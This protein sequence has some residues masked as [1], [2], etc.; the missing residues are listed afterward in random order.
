MHG[1]AGLGSMLGMRQ[2]FVWRLT[3]NAAKNKYE[4]EPCYPDGS[5]PMSAKDATN[6]KTFEEANGDLA[7]LRARGDGFAYT[8]GFWLT[9]ATGFLFLD[10]DECI[11]DGKLNKIADLFFLSLPGACYEWSSSRRGMHLF[12]RGDVGK[13]AKR[14]PKGMGIELY[15]H[16]RGIAFGLDGQV[17]GNADMDHSSAMQWIVS[18]YFPPGQDA[19]EVPDAEFFD[20]DP[21]WFGPT[22]DGMLVRSMERAINLNAAAIFGGVKDNKLTFADLFRRD[23]ARLAARFP[24]GAGGYD[25]SQADAAMI[26]MLAFWTG[27]NAPRI[28][29]IMRQSQ[30]YREKWDENREAK[31]FL[32]YSIDRICRMHKASGNTVL[33]ARTQNVQRDNGPSIAPS[34]GIPNAGTTSSRVGNTGTAVVP[35]SAGNVER[36]ERVESV[37]PFAPSIPLDEAGDKWEVSRDYQAQFEKAASGQEVEAV[38]SAI[39][40]DARSTDDLAYSLGSDMHARFKALGIAKPLAWCRAQCA[41]ETAIVL[42][43][44]G[45]VRDKDDNIERSQTNVNIAMRRLHD[46][47]RWD[48]FTGRVIVGSR[49]LIEVDYGRCM[50]AAEAMGVPPPTIGQVRIAINSVAHESEFDS[51]QEWINSLAWDGIERIDTSLIHLFG[52]EDTPYHQAVG[53]YMWTALAGRVLVPGVKADSIPV[54][55]S[56]E[57]MSKTSFVEALPPTHEYY[58]LLSMDAKAD[59]ISRRIKGKMVMEW[60]ELDGMNPAKRTRMLAFITQRHEKWVEKFETAETSYA[61]RMLVIATS[62]NYYFL[63]AHATE[64]R[65]LPVLVDKQACNIPMLNLHREQLWAEA[66]VR[67]LANGVEWQHAQMTAPAERENFREDDVMEAHVLAFINAVLTP[68]QGNFTIA[69]MIGW[70]ETERGVRARHSQQSLAALLKRLGYVVWKSNGRKIWKKSILSET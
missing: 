45:F 37:F 4:K 21:T 32:R 1:M 26:G 12:C 35:A 49:P 53:K 40:L 25:E 52:I 8:I 11:V 61:R 41:P 48:N 64:R 34:T 30:L 70:M 69:Q 10:V 3:W 58:G 42:R 38:A 63:D 66:R 68:T 56:G 59:D 54:F 57:G 33:G 29:R 43:E 22:D 55:I 60:G 27:R 44:D 31:T 13:H 65:M 2:W 24:D 50:V 14:G 36:P 18:T 51:A 23:T 46:G 6:W 47:L 17:Y 67:F 7:R 20:A 19:D 39:R 5:G 9:A 15:S 62:N 28:D 16:D